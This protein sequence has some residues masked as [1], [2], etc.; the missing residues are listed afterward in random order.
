[1]RVVSCGLGA[2]GRQGGDPAGG[3]PSPRRGSARS[4]PASQLPPAIEPPT[5]SPITRRTAAWR[6]RG[7]APPFTAADLCDRPR[8]LPPAPPSGWSSEVAAL[9]WAD[10]A[11]STDGRRHARH[12]LQQDKPQR[13][14]LDGSGAATVA[15]VR[16]RGPR[17]RG[18]RF[19]VPPLTIMSGMNEE[20]QNPVVEIDGVR[21]HLQDEGEALRHHGCAAQES[22]RLPPWIRSF[23]M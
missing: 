8:H 14:D 15:A 7:Q 23:V 16:Q 11:D 17:L 22:A 1:M 18:A 13:G 4:W 10:G 12:R 20:N 2:R 3:S 19:L 21:V 9:R 5:C 6:G